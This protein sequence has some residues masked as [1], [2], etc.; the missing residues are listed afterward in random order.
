MLQPPSDK[1]V[2]SLGLCGRLA[3]FLRMGD[4]VEFGLQHFAA[5]FL[6]TPLDLVAVLGIGHVAVHHGLEVLVAADL[7]HVCCMVSLYAPLSNKCPTNPGLFRK[8]K[9]NFTDPYIPGTAS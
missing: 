6:Q 1:T 8:F 4:L 9:K 7:I 5:L 2:L 3:R